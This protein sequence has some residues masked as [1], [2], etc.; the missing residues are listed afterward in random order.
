MVIFVLL[1]LLIYNCHVANRHV[2]DNAAG[3]QWFVAFLV[4]WFLL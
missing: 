2:R 3:F 1:S 4:S